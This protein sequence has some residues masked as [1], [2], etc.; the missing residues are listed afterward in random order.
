MKK[1]LLLI[2][3]AVALLIVAFAIPSSAQEQ[4]DIVIL[5][6]NDVHCEILG[7]LS[8]SAM[9]NELKQEYEHV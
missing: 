3:V 4:S 7:Y 1:R 8:L 5:Y 6:E 2:I 9:R